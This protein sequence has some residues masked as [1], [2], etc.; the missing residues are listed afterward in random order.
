MSQMHVLCTLFSWNRVCMSSCEQECVPDNSVPVTPG[1]L[2]LHFPLLGAGRGRAT[3]S[4]QT[5]NQCNV[6]AAMEFSGNRH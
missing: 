1:L 5:Y 4:L 6:T 3:D 2:C